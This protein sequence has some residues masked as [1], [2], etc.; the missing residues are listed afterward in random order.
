MQDDHFIEIVCCLGLGV[1]V[2]FVTTLMECCRPGR[3]KDPSGLQINLNRDCC[4]SLIKRGLIVPVLLVLLLALVMLN[5]AL[6]EETCLTPFGYCASISCICGNIIWQ[7]YVFMF[8]TLSLSPTLLLLGVFRNAKKSLCCSRTFSCYQ[9]DV[10][11]FE[12]RSSVRG[13]NLLTVHEFFIVW[14]YIIGA[15]F[16]SITGM[17][18]YLIKGGGITEEI[19]HAS[20]NLHNIG[21]QV[22][23][24]KKTH[25]QHLLLLIVVPMCLFVGRTIAT[26]FVFFPRDTKGI[27]SSWPLE[28]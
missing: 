21:V 19:I 14:P 11:D 22:V 1:S 18:P 4:G 26:C 3:V 23:R 6:Q 15:V 13:N 12:N 24:R 5:Y 27:R 17:M 7:G 20:D 28:P 2:V 25:H 16:V 8:V 10:P 9:Y